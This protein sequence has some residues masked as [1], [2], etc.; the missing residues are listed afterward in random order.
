MARMLPVECNGSET[1]GAYKAVSIYNPERQWPRLIPANAV[2]VSIFS[3]TEQAYGLLANISEVGACIVSGVQH[4]PGSS[5]LVRIEFEAKRKPF[6]SQAKVV[7]SRDETEPNKPASF[8]HG[9]RFTNVTEEQ[10]AE[11]KAVIDHPKFQKPVVPGKT[12]KEAGELDKMMVEMSKD[13]EDLG[14]KVQGKKD[15]L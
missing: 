13:L 14:S 2:M 4:V 6:S 5:I 9:I 15:P 10:L 11:L 12:E 3:G 1:K 8:V 7:W